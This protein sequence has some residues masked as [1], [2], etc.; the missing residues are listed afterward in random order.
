M[1]FECK[2]YVAPSAIASDETKRGI[3]PGIKPGKAQQIKPNS[4][5]KY[6]LWLELQLMLRRDK[7]SDMKGD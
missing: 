1:T 7:G 6:D 4:S 2:N 3:K 5:W